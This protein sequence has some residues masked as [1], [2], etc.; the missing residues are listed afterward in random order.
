MTDGGWHVSFIIH[1]S[2]GCLFAYVVSFACVDGGKIWGMRRI[3]KVS[4][5]NI[6][7]KIIKEDLFICFDET[8]TERTSTECG[9]YHTGTRYCGT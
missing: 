7:S 8:A 9:Y 3:N 2:L 5:Q 6:I 4:Q 1:E